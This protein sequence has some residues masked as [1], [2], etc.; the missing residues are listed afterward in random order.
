MPITESQALALLSVAVY[1]DRTT[2][3]DGHNRD[4]PRPWFLTAAYI[5]AAVSYAA[6]SHRARRLAGLASELRPAALLQPSPG[7]IYDGLPESHERRGAQCVV[8]PISIN[9]GIGP[10]QDLGN[11]I[12]S[13]YASA[14]K[15]ARRI[16]QTLCL[17]VQRD[18]K[19]G[20]CGKFPL[21]DHGERIG[22]F[23][24]DV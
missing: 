17:E 18:R 12:E 22:I 10:C 15:T 7:S 11:S 23:V 13:T 9:R 8:G 16:A 1:E 5:V 19:C 24:R 21:P 3:S 6:R 2:D 20:R 4:L 14:G